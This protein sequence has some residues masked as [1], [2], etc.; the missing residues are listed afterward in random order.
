[1]NCTKIFLCG[2]FTST[3]K[4]QYPMEI[5]QLVIITI[6]RYRTTTKTST[7]IKV[8]HVGRCND[9][10]YKS[11]NKITWQINLGASASLAFRAN[12]AVVIK[13][14]FTSYVYDWYAIFFC[15]KKFS[16]T[17][18]TFNGIVQFNFLRIMQIE[19]AKNRTSDTRTPI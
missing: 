18:N 1:M 9:I 11:S 6:S 13:H 8:I 10:S 16:H 19:T 17:R 7:S 4:L 5:D 2:S 14:L 3:P 12:V 15:F